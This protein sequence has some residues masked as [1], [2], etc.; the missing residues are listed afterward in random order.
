MGKSSKKS[1]PK[2]YNCC[3][4]SDYSTPTLTDMYDNIVYPVR[5]SKNNNKNTK[6]R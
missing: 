6:K 1:L 2:W 3:L 4:G 5:I